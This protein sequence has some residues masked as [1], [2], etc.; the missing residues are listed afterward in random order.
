MLGPVV[1]ALMVVGTAHAFLLRGRAFAPPSPA[2]PAL[3]GTRAANEQ[4]E[5]ARATAIGEAAPARELP[6]GRPE[7]PRQV[8]GGG[9]V[10]VNH[11]PAQVLVDQ[12]GLSPA[13][14]GAA[15]TCTVSPGCC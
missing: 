13:Q 14:V 5:D 7:L 8:D 10:D 9:L 11:V 2:Q 12:L 3:A 6:V 15:M 4:R 1:L